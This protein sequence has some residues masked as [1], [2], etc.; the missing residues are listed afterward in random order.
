MYTL[1][2]IFVTDEQ[3]QILQNEGVPTPFIDAEAGRCYLVMPIE[4]SA[5]DYGIFRAQIPG[6][7]AV[8]E[9]KVPSDAAIA[10]A[11]LFRKMLEE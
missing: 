4:F 8:A 10:L 5:D 6:I 11:L 3:R 7:S 9:A 1:Q 2:V